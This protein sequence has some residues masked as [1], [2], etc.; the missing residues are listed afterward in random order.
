LPLAPA[1]LKMTVMRALAA[2]AVVGLVAGSLASFGAS[3]FNPDVGWLVRSDLLWTLA[4]IAAY[5]GIATLY[6]LVLAIPVVL[7]RAAVALRQHER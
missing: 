4:G 7:I 2:L 1:T 3:A 5:I 6:A